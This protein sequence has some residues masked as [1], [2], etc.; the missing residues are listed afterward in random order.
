MADMMKNII[1]PT[2]VKYT[3][4][5]MLAFLF[6]IGLYLYA[7]DK[8]IYATEGYNNPTSPLNSPTNNNC[9]DLLIQNGEQFYLY[10]SKAPT[11]NN[12]N[13]L[14]FAKLSDYANYVNQN[15][16][17]PVLFLQ[18]GSDTQ[19]NDNY[20]IRGGTPMNTWQNNGMD[21]TPPLANGQRAPPNVRTVPFVDANLQHPPFNAYNTPGYAPFDPHGFD[22]G[23]FNPLDA[24]HVSGELLPVSDSPT[25]PNWGGTEYTAQMVNSGKYID[26][27]VYRPI[28]SMGNNVT[29]A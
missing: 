4:I 11:V 3:F 7:T 16:G 26:N 19:G 25:D 20:N 6:L 2:F 18:K 22:V 14:V 9:P 27:E 28:F 5:I 1:S 23:R 10:N 21:P 12:V 24:I 29:V 17:C 8:L 15:P 13:P